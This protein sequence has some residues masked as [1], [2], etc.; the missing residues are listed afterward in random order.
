MSNQVFISHSSKDSNIAN[1]VCHILED[2]GVRC[3]IAPRDIPSGSDW[4]TSI[5]KAIKEAE[6]VVLLFSNSANQS[7]FVYREVERAAH[8][9]CPI[10]P[11]RLEDI[12]PQER[13]ELF[14]GASHWLDA[15]DEPIEIQLDKIAQAVRDFSQGQPTNSSSKPL[16]EPVF[17]PK[18][19][20]PI[21]R[22]ANF[23]NRLS[24]QSKAGIYIFIAISIIWIIFQQR[25]PYGAFDPEQ[26]SEIYQQMEPPTVPE[27]PEIPVI[28]ALPE[29]YNSLET[30]QS[31]REIQQA[32]EIEIE[33]THR[34]LPVPEAA[35]LKAIPQ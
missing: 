7:D 14:I 5:I 22:F 19:N 13:L 29:A 32:L 8:H 16:T 26:L 1:A 30:E 3:W 34:N 33:E 17:P 24:T 28:P 20:D 12:L 25:R 6:M 31:L 2:T 35:A 10:L 4:S 21:S 9:Q 23:Y 11:V 18:K 27:I 15:I